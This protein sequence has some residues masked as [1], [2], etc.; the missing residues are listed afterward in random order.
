M[1][2][3]YVCTQLQICKEHAIQLEQQAQEEEDNVEGYQPL[4]NS[5]R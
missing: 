5:G 4:G 1:Y 3:H 2:I